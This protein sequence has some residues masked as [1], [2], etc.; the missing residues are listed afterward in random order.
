MLE[1]LRELKKKIEDAEYV[2]VCLGPEFGKIPEEWDREIFLPVASSHLLSR[3]HV[4]VVIS[5]KN[6][7][8][9][10][11]RA[12][13]QYYFQVKRPERVKELYA[14][15]VE[16]LKDKNYF[17]VSTLTDGLVY[18]SGLDEERIVSPCGREDKMQC[19]KG[20]TDH[21]WDGRYMIEYFITE[22]EA[23][24]GQDIGSRPP[25]CPH[26]KARAVFH[27]KEDYCNYREEGYLPQWQNY[28]AWLQ[29]TM[30]RKTVM[31]EL[32]ED[33]EHPSVARFPFEKM[34]F[35]NQKAELIRVNSKLYQIPEEAAERSVG[36]QMEPQ[37]F[38]GA[39]AE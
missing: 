32:G 30:N 14:P 34:A 4:E 28:M 3:E 25:V 16:L 22:I 31:L 20:C 15:L 19:Q 12:L 18:Y 5:N 7:V 24:R 10:L 38:V 27:V 2:V 11:C 33:F 37:E 39:L 9:W 1:N 26:C 8:N 36:I 17:I 29:N 21:I 6:H 35:V 23:G 13:K